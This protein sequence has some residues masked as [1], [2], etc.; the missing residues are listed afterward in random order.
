MDVMDDGC[1]VM[2]ESQAELYRDTFPRSAPAYY[3][4]S[5]PEPPARSTVSFVSLISLIPS[6]KPMPHP[7]LL[8]ESQDWGNRVEGRFSTLAAEQAA[9]SCLLVLQDNS[10]PRPAWEGL[11]LFFFF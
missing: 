7:W 5:H 4:K 6:A 1:L 10:K 9:L 11:F 8:P 3:R 2:P